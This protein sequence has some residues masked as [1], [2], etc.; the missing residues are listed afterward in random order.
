MARPAYQDQRPLGNPTSLGCAGF[1]N[2]P[3]SWDVIGGK[4]EFMA[5]AIKAQICILKAQ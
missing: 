1:D 5:A 4:G 2:V 3:A